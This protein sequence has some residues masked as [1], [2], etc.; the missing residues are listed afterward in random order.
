MTMLGEPAASANP[1]SQF[2]QDVK[3]TLAVTAGAAASLAEGWDRM[4]PERRQFMI[5]LL[6]RRTA[7]LQAQL[8]PVLDRMR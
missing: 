8:A 5:D 3:N 4:P 1:V 7:E 6:A 2:R